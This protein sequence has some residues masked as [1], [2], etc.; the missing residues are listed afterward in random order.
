MDFTL[1]LNSRGRVKQLERFVS[2]CEEKTNNHS[3]VEMIIT[4]DND[5]LETVEFLSTLKSRN[6]FLFNIIIGD[7][8]KSLC[9]SYNNMVNQALGKYLFVMNDDAE[10]VTQN[11]D[12][13]AL[14]KIADYKKQ[15]QYKD[16]IIYGYTTDISADKIEGKQY[17]AFPIVSSEATRVL[18]FFMYGQFVGLGGD[19]SLYRIYE[20]VDRIVDMREIVVDHVYHNTILRVLTPDKTGYEMRMNTQSSPLNPF[21]FN[22]DNDVKRLKEFIKETNETRN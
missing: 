3:Q 4:G 8:P 16:N 2:I 1:F 21:D 18:G 7:R 13:I 22:I 12:I 14:Q 20:A 5:D 17:A 6:T 9:G 19:S 10:I 11:W 15:T